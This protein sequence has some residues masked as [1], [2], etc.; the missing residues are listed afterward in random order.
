MKISRELILT[1]GALLL[2]VLVLTAGHVVIFGYQLTTGVLNFA[3]AGP[4]LVINAIF[5][6]LLFLFRKDLKD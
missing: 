3:Q 1:G 4:P 6:G 5:T 2:I